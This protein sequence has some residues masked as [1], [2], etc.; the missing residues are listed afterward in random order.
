MLTFLLGTYAI[1]LFAS[2]IFTTKRNP[3]VQ[4][5]LQCSQMQSIQIFYDIGKGYNIE[6]SRITKTQQSR[7]YQIVT[8]ELPND[9]LLKELRIDLGA[10]PGK[11]K[12]KRISLI[13]RFG[14]KDYN[15]TEIHEKFIA[16]NDIDGFI[17][18]GNAINLTTNGEDPIILSNFAIDKTYKDLAAVRPK[19]MLPIAITLI[20]VAGLLI[21]FYRRGKKI[22]ISPSRQI[23]LLGF[24][25]FMI[26]PLFL[27]ITK[28]NQ[29]Q[30]N[31]EYR[32]K[33][34]APKWNIENWDLYLKKYNSY[35][36]DQFG[37]RS[38]L[39]QFYAKYKTKIWKT[40]PVPDKVL[41]GKENWLFTVED[42]LMEDYRGMNKFSDK[43]LEEIYKNLMDRKSRLEKM[44]IGYY[45]VIAPNKQTVYPEY[46]P[47]RYEPI[48]PLNRWKQTNKFLTSKGVDFIVD[49]TEEFKKNKE[50]Y[51]I[52]YK[53]DLHWNNMGAFITSQLLLSEIS[54]KHLVKRHFL[55]EYSISEVPF[56]KGD[57][58]RMIC[59]NQIEDIEYE[60]NSSSLSNIQYSLGEQ[61]PS[62][63]STQPITMTLNGD[64][65]KPNVLFFK[66]SFGN[67]M[68][69][70][71]SEE[72]HKAIYVWTHVFDWAI[73]E[74]EKPDIVIHEISE[75][76]IHKF[77]EE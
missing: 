40:S 18:D 43:N 19:V 64:T 24:F 39:I 56:T 21:L 52:Y 60:F 59:S 1:F 4:I 3:S 15:S 31:T 10:L 51:S 14:K 71:I 58:A 38:E 8:L 9:T 7:D 36:E 20:I 70:F 41:I 42:S 57:L 29:D 66:D 69:Q 48:D 49:P 17:N 46:V 72:S 73:I 35:F 13:N 37:M 23:L 32:A 74:K 77:L 16:H 76:L 62:Y 25:T 54:K 22:K 63:V 65:S 47:E 67:G 61:Y 26:T 33:S 44:G 6:D 50:K 5:E 55:N 53:T 68:T 30:N 75:K 27:F 2:T 11:Y 45:V 28:R 34:E 12:I